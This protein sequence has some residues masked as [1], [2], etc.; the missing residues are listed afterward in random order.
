M[1][2]GDFFVLKGKAS[3]FFYG[4]RIRPLRDVVSIV[5]DITSIATQFIKH[6]YI[7]VF[8]Q[9]WE[10]DD[11]SRLVID[12][13][14]ISK[15]FSLVKNGTYQVRGDDGDARVIE[16]KQARAQIVEAY[17]STPYFMNDAVVNRDRYREYSLS[18]TLAYSAQQLET[19][20]ENN[21]TA[22][23][24]TYVKK[25]VE[26]S[27]RR[28]AMLMLGHARYSAVPKAQRQ[29]IDHDAALAFHDILERRFGDDMKC[30]RP[31]FVEW[32]DDNR[33][34]LM[35]R[36]DERYA[37]FDD[38]IENDP[39][40]FLPVMVRINRLLEMLPSIDVERYASTKLYSPLVLRTSYIPSH[41]CIDTT[42]LLHIFVDNVERFKMWY[43][44]RFGV[45][46]VNL[47]D[48]TSLASSYGSLVNRS[49]VTPGEESLHADRCWE[50][51]GELPPEALTQQREVRK[52][53]LPKLSIP[54]DQSTAKKMSKKAAAA[55]AKASIA[56]SAQRKPDDYE[57]KDL[58]FHR[59][60]LTD[61]YNLSILLT[62]AANLRGKVVGSRKS[63]L[64]LPRLDP[65]TSRQFGYLLP[66]AVD[67]D[68]AGP[69]DQPPPVNNFNLVSCDPGKKKPLHMIDGQ[70]NELIHT[71]AKR[72]RQCRHLQTQRKMLKMKT[73]TIFYNANVTLA[74]GEVMQNP[75]VVDIETRYL[76]D[77]G[78][79]TCYGD[80]YI[81]R[82]NARAVV[83]PLL[84]PFYEKMYFRSSKYAV[85]IATKSCNDKLFDQIRNTFGKG[86]KTIVIF[87]GN[88]GMRPNALRNGP[89]TPGI[90]LRRLIHR[91]L[92]NDRRNGTTH[93][94]FT[95]TVL[96][97]RTSSVGAVAPRGSTAAEYATHVEETSRTLS[98]LGAKNITEYCDANTTDARGRGTGT[99][100]VARTLQCRHC[101]F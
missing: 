90:G 35:P 59:M 55:A 51:V 85:Y 23:F 48:K 2:V 3:Q 24:S 8:F 41:M 12:E 42:S 20:Y 6:Y 95:V 101:I 18:F 29:A 94:G 33:S 47:K 86:D 7:N 89:P 63:R 30:A 84:K 81:E 78:L 88:W 87:W 99:G 45:E 60:M 10:A 58:R 75:T 19:A 92:T 73:E 27:L 66:Q 65:D 74:D 53:G 100:L 16:A 11:T 14:F 28:N 82:L 49:D 46:L 38:H 83:A 70:G 22:H 93:F 57:V 77:H 96:E 44:Q 50:Y 43:R 32:I 31:E 1:P 52:R 54:G 91:R 62:T 64:F 5:H 97:M 34:R 9:A 56:A 80:D 17:V 40:V 76:R 36:S 61:G 72:E 25:Y 26:T 39:F 15:V 37:S 21:I 69:S 13:D 98:T 67:P 4:N 71:H 68:A 79:K